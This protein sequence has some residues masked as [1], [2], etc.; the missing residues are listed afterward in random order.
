VS[1]KTDIRIT[2]VTVYFLP[3]Q[4]RMPYRFGTEQ[5]DSVTCVRV[6]VTVENGHGK[7]GH[8]WGETP[9]SAPWAWPAAHL[10][11]SAR[12]SAMKAFCIELGK[13][14]AACDTSG[15]PLEIGHSLQ[16]T[17]LPEARLFFDRQSG[18]DA[19][20][21]LAALVCSSA[22]DLALHDAYGL[23]NNV[24]IYETYTAE[25]LNRDLAHFLEPADDVDF[26][27]DGKYPVD[28]IVHPRPNHLPAWHAVGG[29]DLLDDSERNGSEPKDQYPV[30]L[31]DW[32]KA[33]G[34]TCLK[35]KLTGQEH[36][37]DYERIVKIGKIGIEQ[38]ALWLC[39]DFNCTVK[40]V[41]YVH[42][43]LDR[44]MKDHPRI[45]Q[46]ILYVEQPFAHDLEAHPL[47]VHSISSR[48]PLF[49]D[50]SAH[51]WR[52]VRL[53]RKLGWTGVALKTCKTQTGAILS[54][55]WARAHGMG[56]MVQDLTN[57]ML[58]QIPHVLL[59]AYA[60]TIMGM[61]T[62]AMQ[63]YP[64]A[65]LPEAEVH[66]GVYRR[67]DGQL[68]ISTLTGPGFGYQLDRI[69]RKLPEAAAAF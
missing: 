9:L 52:I 43:I 39:T 26:S 22:F 34:L 37:W 53:G 66:P 54:L 55:C 5:L 29:N 25:Y 4:T 45:Y 61:E 35:I 47:D 36:G 41:D 33:D 13:V 23:V 50:E 17:I 30:V 32:I 49:M 21:Q 65:S 69:G 48:K 28:Y 6:C 20:P 38:G 68:D 15:H 44:L 46:M 8:G 42:D 63:F 16:E 24:N 19:M 67:K 59:T 56:L 1:K 40:S 7:T 18:I 51:D 64:D 14:W 62:N 60:G 58:A 2:G 27:F 31:P 10:S 57:P 3:V 12:E 11:Y